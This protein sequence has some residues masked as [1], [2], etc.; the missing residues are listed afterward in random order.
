LPDIGFTTEK[1]YPDFS[2]FA[3]Y[4]AQEETLLDSKKSEKIVKKFHL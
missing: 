4:S 3:E 2:A 1:H